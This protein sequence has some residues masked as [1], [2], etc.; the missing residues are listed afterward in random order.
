MEYLFL[1]I[2]F[3]CF[4]LFSFFVE[5]FLSDNF[6]R[7]TFIVTLASI[8]LC[9]YTLTFFLNFFT[10]QYA[11]YIFSLFI[12][13]YELKKHR[14]QSLFHF[15]KCYQTVFILALSWFFLTINVQI[16]H[17]D[18]FSW[19]IFVKHLNFFGQYWTSSS[20]VNQIGLRY[21]PGLSLWET[22]FTGKNYYAEQP[23]FFA[24]G[25]ICISSFCALKPLSFTKKQTTY[26]FILFTCAISW[27]TIGIGS[28]STEASMGFILAA[29]FIATIDVKNARDLLVPFILTLFMAIT[30]ETGFLLALLVIFLIVVR[31]IREKNFL[32]KELVYCITCLALMI[33]NYS[34]WQWYLK[35][36]PQ[37]A[38]L[39]SNKLLEL[40]QQDLKEL[41]VRSRDTLNTF[42]QA[43]Y[44]RPI[45]RSF[46]SRLP[47]PGFIFI[48][49]FYF[50]W[51]AII[52]IV[53]FRMRERYEYLITF[54]FGL[55]GYTSVLLVTFL[56]MFGKEEGKALASYER[57]IGVYFLAFAIV[58]IKIILEKELWSEKK[59]LK[60]LLVLL[61][62][63]P[64]SPKVLHPPTIANLVPDFIANKVS[65]KKNKS[66]QEVMSIATKTKS[67]TPQ[68]SKVWFIWQHTSG[69]QTMIMRYEMAPRR[70]IETA[71]SLGSKYDESDIWTSPY[72]Q[73]EFSEA[74]KNA[75]YMA[76][77][78]IDENFI[79]NYGMFF[80]SLPKSD[81]IYKK[82]VVNNS[83]SLT[84]IQ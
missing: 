7:Y 48:K 19:G 44:S 17:W 74:L 71:W 69:I 56:Y 82:E 8:T 35:S 75:D 59:F 11:L 9:L 36:D 13:G 67:L 50:F 25:L 78:Y 6:K 40:F 64:P 58:C 81:A 84:E 45:A 31:L 77:G 73:E 30:K 76:L 61:F 83:I 70:I 24:L 52:G 80:T 4:I 3:S 22:F 47:I 54:F 1:L 66:R 15:F 12:L 5:K 57:Y 46:L 37:V 55:I 21:F 29:A 51:V 18:D 65:L 53:L 43:L 41:S 79:K 60:A 63:F 34:L 39:D 49:G 32:S 16:V 27:F 10:I 14:G 23:I 28:I 42:F 72:T 33:L 68:D 2:G 62:I 20:A 26:L 38:A